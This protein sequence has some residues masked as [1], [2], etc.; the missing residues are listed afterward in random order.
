MTQAGVMVVS[1]VSVLDWA[2]VCLSCVGGGG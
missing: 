2:W 1:N